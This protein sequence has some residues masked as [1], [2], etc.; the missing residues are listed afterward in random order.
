MKLQS[1]NN[2]TT[3]ILS[4]SILS[5]ILDIHQRTL[6]IYDKEKILC[7]LRTDKNR[8]L[9]SL[10]DVEKAKLILFLT[11]NIGVNL[12][13]VKIILEFIVKNETEPK[14]YISFINKI[15]QMANI[16]EKIQEN[17]IKKY[18]KRGKRKKF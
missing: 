15:A 11:R 6:R 9:Y 17:N 14:D 12:A 3:P 16:T 5:Q 13:G 7:P 1:N 10:N 8:R 18:S 4:I 2:N